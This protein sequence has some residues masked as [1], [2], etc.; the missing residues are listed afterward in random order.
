MAQLWDYVKSTGLK[1][2]DFLFGD[3]DRERR[4]EAI[5]VLDK[6][7]QQV[8]WGESLSEDEARRNVREGVIELMIRGQHSSNGLLLT[9][10]GY[11]LTAKHCLDKKLTESYPSVRLHDGSLH[12][13]ERICAYSEKDDVV[14][15]KAKIDGPAKVRS[16][17]VWQGERIDSMP[18][19]A[20]TRWYGELQAKNGF[21]KTSNTGLPAYS[22][23][24][25]LEFSD[26]EKGDSGGVITTY[27]GRVIGIHYMATFDGK[28]KRAQESFGVTITRAFEIL[29]AHKRYLEKK[30]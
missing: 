1:A 20:V 9:D 5:E 22:T 15:A 3:E 8:Y 21:L 24:F 13:L 30:T 14:L 27:D 19:V 2:W 12:A 10:N 28:S 18:V 26:T 29:H 17:R 23:G 25:R 4:K 7:I 16:Y 6:C 11:F